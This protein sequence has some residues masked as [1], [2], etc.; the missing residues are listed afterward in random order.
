MKPL[1]SEKKLKQNIDDI[2]SIGF[3]KTGDIFI[4]NVKLNQGNVSVR[5]APVEN[6]LS[7][8]FN[9]IFIY[10]K[11]YSLKTAQKLITIT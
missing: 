1:L 9:D 6:T 4:K 2:K 11:Q 7:V 5:Y 3:K 10:D 8:Y